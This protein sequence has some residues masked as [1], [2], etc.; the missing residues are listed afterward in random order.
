[1]SRPSTVSSAPFVRYSWARWIGFRVWKP[2]TR[3]QPRSA[4]A[5]RVS[6]GSSASSGKLDSARSNT[7]TGPPRYSGVLLVEPRDARMRVLG[8]A[9]AALGLA[10]LVVPVDV[11]ST[12]STATVRPVLVGERDA[13]ALRRLRH[14]EADRQRPGQAERE[15]HLGDD[16]LV[17]GL[18]HEALERRERAR[19]DHVE[20]AQLAR[21]QRDD[22]ERVEVVGP[23][24]R[25]V[26]ERAAVRRDEARHQ[27]ATSSAQ[28]AELLELGDDQVGALLR[29]VRLRVDH[30]LRSPG[31]SYGSSTPVKPLISPANAFA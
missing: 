1:M 29:R 26:D 30:E 11:S 8:R 25:A 2:T 5:A 16:P 14:G 10:R 27:A 21:R 24:A 31:S 22:L 6:A 19:G 15:P 17:V 4:K 3:F 13:V 9:V 20:V 18:A 28:Q 7:V 23:V 12:S